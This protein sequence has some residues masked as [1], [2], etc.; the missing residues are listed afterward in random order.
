MLKKR[1]PFQFDQNLKRTRTPWRSLLTGHEQSF[2]TDN[3]LSAFVSPQ[4]PG[5]ERIHFYPLPFAHRFTGGRWNYEELVNHDSLRSIGPRLELPVDQVN[6]TFRPDRIVRSGCDRSR[7][8]RTI[9]PAR[10]C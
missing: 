2:L 5:C 10:A 3:Q 8:G 6:L 4:G 1:E 7:R 9:R